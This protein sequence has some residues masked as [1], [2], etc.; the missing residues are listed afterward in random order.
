MDRR[1]DRRGAL[2]NQGRRERALSAARGVE[3]DRVWRLG[4]GGEIVENKVPT[5]KPSNLIE[6]V[7]SE[8]AKMAMK[9]KSAVLRIHVLRVRLVRHEAC[10]HAAPEVHVASNHAESSSG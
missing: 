6:S 10:G 3:M 2:V 4:R 1:S 9:A 8:A 5:S 7:L